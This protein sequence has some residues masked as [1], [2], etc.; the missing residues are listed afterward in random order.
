[1]NRQIKSRA[2]WRGGLGCKLARAAFV[3][4]YIAKYTHGAHLRKVCIANLAA[5]FGTFN[6]PDGVAWPL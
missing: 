4:G 6:G 3:C 2:G 5:Q 1:M